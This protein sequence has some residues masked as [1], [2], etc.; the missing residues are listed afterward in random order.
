MRGIAGVAIS[1]ALVALV[2]CKQEKPLTPGEGFINVP[3]GKVW[4]RIAGGGTATPLLHTLPPDA[5]VIIE[6]HER[7]GTTNTPEYQAAMQE[8]YGRYLSRR[9]PWSPDTETTLADLN[10][11]VY[12]YKSLVPS[13]QKVII[14]NAGHL[15]MQDQPEK[16]VAAVRAFLHDVER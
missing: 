13:A 1:V 10:P 14:E 4:Y 5:Q 2:A 12:T 3:G 8:Y 7:E 11:D 9:Q 15:T 6:R 16:F